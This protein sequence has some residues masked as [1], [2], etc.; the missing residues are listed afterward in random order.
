V[1]AAAAPRLS[2]VV[3]THDRPA[4][5]AR[6]L[7]Q[8]A[9][10]TLPATD[11]EVVVVDDGSAEPVAPALAARSFPYA[12]RVETQANAGA[13]AARHRGAVAA[14]GALLVVVDDD[15]EVG[16]DFLERHL[17]RHPEGSRKVVLGAIRPPPSIARLPLFERWGQ[18]SLE[19]FAARAL[20][21]GAVRG[22]NVYTGNVSFRRADYVAVGGFDAALGHSE[23]AELGLRLEKAGVAFEVAPD[24]YTVNGTDHT[25]LAR[26]RRRAR[27]YG[28]FD[29]R[30]AR[31]HRDLRHASPWRFLPDLNPVARTVIL[32]TVLAPPVA[33]A[34]A[35]AAYGVAAAADRLGLERAALAGVNFSYGLEYYGGVRGEAGAAGTLRELADWALSMEAPPGSAGGLRRV[36]LVRRFAADVR[37]DHDVLR[38]YEAKYGHRAPSSGRLAA[39]AVQKIGLQILVAVRLMRLL[40]DAGAPLAAKAASRLIRHA[41][42]S[43][44]HWDAEL[45]P[46]VNLVHGFGLA[47]SG[48]AKVGSGCILFQNVTLGWATDPV[49]RRGGAPTLERNV[50][51]MPG[52]TLL[53]PIVVGEGS[54]VM[55]GAVLTRSVP[56]GSLVETAAP[57]VKVRPRRAPVAVADAPVN[58]P[59]AEA[60][61]P[62]AGGARGR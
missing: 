44:I 18:R 19:A 49:T 20:A 58:A 33:R 46:G 59:E 27:L 28:V 24:A 38:G 16:P 51:V 43:D 8:L 14:R 3:A 1:S 9:R 60:G 32:G 11:F 50:H 6:L 55:A 42:G 21:G 30:I 23:D 53:G 47:V 56:P 45:E 25:S 37:A 10:Q 15:M 31:K 41:Y 54:K 29:E 17:A 36:R 22:N 40:R 12:L 62:R 52:A 35:G 48:A 4:L 13:A 2:V 39:D 61:A 7:E 57:E 26:W 5:L 34:I